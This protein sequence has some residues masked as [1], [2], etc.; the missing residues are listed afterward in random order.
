MGGREANHKHIA[1]QT[2]AHASLIH[3]RG[4]DLKQ[5]LA[6]PAGEGISTC[7]LKARFAAP[8]EDM[9]ARCA[10]SV[11]RPDIAS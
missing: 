6:A 9:P 1:G 2:A 11:G 5:S 8:H 7:S 4:M 10:L 3:R